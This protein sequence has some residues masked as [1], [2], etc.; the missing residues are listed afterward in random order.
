[1]R[2]R[3][4]RLLQQDSHIGLI[5]QL[6][7]ACPI[8]H[9][10]N[11]DDQSK[12]GRMDIPS[13]P[14]CVADDRPPPIMA[15][16]CPIGDHAGD[17]RDEHENLGRI[18]EPVMLQREPA[19]DVVGDMIQKNEPKRD[20]AACI[21]AWVA[22]EQF[23][24]LVGFEWQGRQIFHFAVGSKNNSLTDHHGVIAVQTQSMPQHCGQA[25]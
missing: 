2:Q 23:I 3:R 20:A 22:L 9:D 17:P 12:E 13:S 16:N 5:G 11:G 1:M 4:P 6:C 18:A 15:F 25:H 7:N 24:S 10:D 8:H 21:K 19:A 14:S